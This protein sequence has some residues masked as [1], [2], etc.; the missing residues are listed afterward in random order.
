[1][2]RRIVVSATAHR[3]L[4]RARAWLGRRS[5]AEEVVVLGSTLEAGNELTRRAIP[6][7]GSAFGWH[8][9]SLAQFA[10]L[11]ARPA[12]QALGAVPLSDLGA[13]ALVARV[14]HVMGE[15]G[16]LG[17]YAAIANMPGF[18]RAIAR[19]LAELRLAGIG[20]QRGAPRNRDSV[21]GL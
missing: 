14:V 4:A 19:S 5:A 16:G 17:R 20:P 8:R 9:M 15:A 13:E 12:L 3:R 10:A 18:P 6:T 21:R 2:G 11:L 1:M 7:S